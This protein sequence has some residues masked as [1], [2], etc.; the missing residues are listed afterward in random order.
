MALLTTVRPAEPPGRP[1][2]VVELSGEADLNDSAAL[3][4]LIAAQ[5]GDQTGTLVLDLSG[6]RFMDSAALHAVLVA[7]RSMAGCGGTLALAAPTDAVRRIL[8]LSGGDQLVSVYDSV[9]AAEQ[10]G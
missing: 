1:H 6:L 8:A 10:G 7:A 2:P 5:S 9:A 3:G 4:E